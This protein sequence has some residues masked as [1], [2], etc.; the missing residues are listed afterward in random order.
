MDRW[1]F[2]LINDVYQ[3]SIGWMK[4]KGHVLNSYDEDSS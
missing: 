1:T 4:K 3:F 2:S